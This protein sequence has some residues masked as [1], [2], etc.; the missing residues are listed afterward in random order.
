[1][2]FGFCGRME[3]VKLAFCTMLDLLL[4]ASLTKTGTEQKQLLESCCHVNPF[5]I[6]LDLTVSLLQIYCSLVKKTTE[7]ISVAIKLQFCRILDFQ[8]ENM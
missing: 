6:A 3:Y 2:Y 8:A 1:M 5:A 7:S 4:L